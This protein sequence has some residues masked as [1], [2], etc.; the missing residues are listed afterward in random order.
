MPA[1]YPVCSLTKNQWFEEN[2]AWCAVALTFPE[3]FCGDEIARAGRTY[4]QWYASKSPNIEA[5]PSPA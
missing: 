4:L 3:A 1:K 2:C 5:P